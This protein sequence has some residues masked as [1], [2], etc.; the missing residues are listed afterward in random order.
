MAKAASKTRSAKKRPAAPK[1]V[2]RVSKRTNHQALSNP[3]ME[4]LLDAV[5]HCGMQPSILITQG[6][7]SVLECHLLPDCT[8]GNCRAVKP[9]QLPVRLR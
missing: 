1:S 2:R 5:R 9:A 8:Y 4:M 6:D 7:G 3:A